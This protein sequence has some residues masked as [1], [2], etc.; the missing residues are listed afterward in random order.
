M[1]LVMAS[2]GQGLICAW[3]PSSYLATDSSRKLITQALNEQGI[4]L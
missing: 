4:G 1:R 3:L 2:C